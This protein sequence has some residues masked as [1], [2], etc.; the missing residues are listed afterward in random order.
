MNGSL[1]LCRWKWEFTRLQRIITANNHTQVELFATERG[2]DK[3]IVLD[4]PTIVRL[5]REKLLDFKNVTH[6]DLAVL[7][8]EVEADIAR[9]ENHRRNAKAELL[10]L[11]RSREVER[12]YRDMDHS[13]FDC[14]PSLPQFRKLPTLQVFQDSTLDV[15]STPWRNEFVQTLVKNEV[16]E[17]ATKTLRAFSEC[18]GYPEWPSTETLTHPVHWIS[19]R[20][21]CTRCSKTGPKAA[22]NKNLTFCEA[23]RHICIVSEKGNKD[24]W[25]PKNFV[26]DTKAAAV[27]TRF[28]TAIGIDVQE[29]AVAVVISRDIMCL[30]CS[31]PIVMSFSAMTQ[32]SHRHDDMEIMI[33]AD[34][35]LVEFS[36]YPVTPGIT[37]RLTR[38]DKQ[39]KERRSNRC[40]GCKHCILNP[41][42]AEEAGKSSDGR[43]AASKK[44]SKAFNF[45]G[46]RCHLKEKHRVE[47]MADEDF[48]VFDEYLGE[49]GK[50]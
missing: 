37:A 46:L 19:S 2:H 42:L 13:K 30:S 5:L 32:H 45:D 11:Q 38:A 16:Q 27:I 29:A 35:E 4:T 49:W 43:A 48:F 34:E 9:I 36:D 17:W 21:I 23:A 26:V 39:M 50:E 7:W 44:K 14:F 18:L 47:E 40:F 15:G 1:E 28:V 20:F 41:L 22:R 10:R 12:L 25:S 31:G 33:L 3:R 8:P 24:Q 6:N